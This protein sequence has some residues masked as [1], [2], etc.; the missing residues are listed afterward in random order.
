VG[1]ASASLPLGKAVLGTAV[2]VDGNGTIAYFQAT[3]EPVAYLA[4]AV[5][6]LAAPR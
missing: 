2:V 1:V 5:R 4:A 6:R 3:G